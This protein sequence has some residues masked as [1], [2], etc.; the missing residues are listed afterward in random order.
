MPLLAGKLDRR[1]TLQRATITQDALNNDVHEWGPIATV[2]GSK[3][4]ASARERL[5]ADEVGADM[6]MVFQIRWSFDVS[7]LNPKDRLVYD[8]RTYDIS[9]VTEIGYRVGLE[10]TAVARA[11]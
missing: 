7:D 1:V 10:I 5:S 8:S 11:D 6:V 4:P 3:R 2:W 9:G